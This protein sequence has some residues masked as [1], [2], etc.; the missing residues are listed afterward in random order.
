MSAGVPAVLPDANIFYSRTLRDWICLLANRSGAPLFHLRWTEDVLA[1]LVYHLRKNHPMYSDQQIGGVRDRILN[2][3]PHGRISGYRIDPD[4]AYT[5]EYD[6]HLHAAAEHGSVQ[7]VITNDKDF[8]AF[9]DKCDEHLGYE[10]YTADDFLMLVYQD[11]IATVRETLLE[12]IAYHRQRGAPFNLVARLD[13]AQAPNFAAAIR[14]M[15]QTP[16]VA[17]ALTKTTV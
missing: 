3:V 11:A 12:Q 16:A 5:D 4:L 13:S 15:M 1:E 6:A 14:G 10:V 9:A 17:A 8:H 2:V 7:Y